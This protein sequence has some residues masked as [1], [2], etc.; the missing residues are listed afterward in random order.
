MG[1]GASNSPFGGK[2]RASI[3]FT[4]LYKAYK[5]AVLTGPGSKPRIV[6]G[7]KASYTPSPG[8]SVSGINMPSSTL[9]Y[10]KK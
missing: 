3:Q 7:V 6:S 8:L 5:V 10:V 1:P 4:L 2:T 9:Y